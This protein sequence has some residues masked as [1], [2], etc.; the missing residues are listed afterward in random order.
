MA[1]PRKSNVAKPIKIF[2]HDRVC[3]CLGT[4]VFIAR[5]N[6]DKRS[7]NP[8]TSNRRNKGISMLIYSLNVHEA[9]TVWHQLWPLS[10]SGDGP[11]GTMWHFQGTHLSRKFHS[12][13]IAFIFQTTNSIESFLFLLPSPGPLLHFP[14]K[15]WTNSLHIRFSVGE[16]PAMLIFNLQVTAPSA[17]NPHLRISVCKGESVLGFWYRP[18]KL[19][20]SC[21]S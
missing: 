4:I 9:P 7:L 20:C 14:R 21:W 1:E 11:G 2:F 12:V 16:H 5:G 19:N 17:L 15:I 13:R 8:L 10:L 6:E 3:S 18:D